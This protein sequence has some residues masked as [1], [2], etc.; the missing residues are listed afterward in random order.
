M[1]TDAELAEL[2]SYLEAIMVHFNAIIPDGGKLPMDV[3]WKLAPGRQLVIKQAR[4]LR[5]K[6]TL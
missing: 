2:A 3:E 5:V 6:S 1:L 4:P